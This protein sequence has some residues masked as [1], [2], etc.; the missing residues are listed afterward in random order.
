MHQDRLCLGCENLQFHERN[1]ITHMCDLYIIFLL[2]KFE[3]N[4]LIKKNKTLF[5]VILQPGEN[6]GKVCENSKV[7]ENARLCLNFH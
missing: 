4:N 5:S 3:N 1:K 2:V 6:L 7:G